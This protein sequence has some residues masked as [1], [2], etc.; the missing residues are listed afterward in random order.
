MSQFLWIED[1]ENSPL[2][3]T[4]SVFG[5]PLSLTKIPDTKEEVKNLL[6][7]H[8]VLVEL[9]F[10]EAWQ[11]IHNPQKLLQVDYIILDIDLIVQGEIDDEKG[12]LPAIL[13]LYGY[14]HHQDSENR[15]RSY[16]TATN[17]LKKVAG[18]Q[19]YVELVIN[20]GFPQDHI[21]FCSNHGEEMKNIQAAF[22]TAKMQLPQILT[23]NQTKEIAEWITGRRGNIYAVLRRGIIEGCVRISQLLANHPEFIQFGEFIK[24]DS[25]G[26]P[27][28]K[29]TVK[30]MQE[31]LETLQN[32]LPLREPEPIDKSRCFRTFIRTLVHDWD[33]A[34]P[35][36][37]SDKV[38]STFG[39]IMKNARNWSAHSE[40][41]EEMKEPDV[42]FLFIVAMR[43][44][45]KLVTAT[46]RYESLL[47][48]L[49]NKKITVLDV[50]Q[51][52]LG[53]T[54]SKVK[55]TLLKY[56]AEDALYFNAMLNNMQ[57]HKPPVP[58]DYVTGL[59]QMFWHSL[60]PVKVE[61]YRQGGKVT[62]QSVIFAR[63]YS[64]DLHDYG[65]ADNGFLF[66]LARSIYQRSFP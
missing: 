40:V 16:K 17:A 13:E 23:K 24:T 1:F 45:F 30:D 65:K 43:A 50:N 25:N 57:N 34:E 35:K 44:M 18:Y 52:P 5:G 64:F 26:S 7:K 58:F 38:N 32:L 22:I 47:L 29:V 2:D 54:Y 39:W 20:L 51:I 55:N 60:S 33:A 41:L 28:W 4:R 49:F 46:Q 61:T 14:Q 42:A 27:I 62:N 8:R 21:R 66:E 56:R 6:E 59:F 12:E 11:F 19:L 10:L 9:T 63:K 36:Q 31:Y 48:S 37:G 53:I 3:T 15:R